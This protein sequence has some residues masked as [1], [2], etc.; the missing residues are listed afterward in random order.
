MAT[1]VH[2][3]DVQPPCT[4][5]M[6]AL[7]ADT[8]AV[9]ACPCA[10]LL[11]RPLQVAHGLLVCHL[12]LP[13]DAVVQPVAAAGALAEVAL[14]G[15][16][17]QCL[18]YRSRSTQCQACTQLPAVQSSNAILSNLSTGPTQGCRAGLLQHLPS[19]S[20]NMP[21]VMPQLLQQQRHNHVGTVTEHTGIEEPASHHRSQLTLVLEHAVQV[22]RVVLAAKDL[23]GVDALLS[24]EG[25]HQVDSAGPV[26]DGLA[27]LPWG[28]LLAVA[29]EGSAALCEPI[30]AV[31]QLLDA[32]AA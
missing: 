13:R 27:G 10:A 24:P 20:L 1:T 23:V 22:A 3:R 15:H 2:P 29:P 4:A 18:A 5:G 30:A 16:C 14:A 11:T 19:V 7:C 28:V 25:F 31:L 17:G 32:A 26:R 12:L 6:L 21:D 8:S 9:P